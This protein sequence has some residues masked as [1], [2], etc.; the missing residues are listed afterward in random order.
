MSSDSFATLESLTAHTVRSAAEAVVNRPQTN[1]DRPVPLAYALGM[2]LAMRPDDPI[3]ALLAGN[4]LLIAELIKDCAKPRPSTT[5]RDARAMRAEVLA[6]TRALH[7]GIGKLERMRTHAAKEAA[8]AETEVPA[9]RPEPPVP[10]AE[11]H[12]APQPGPPA[13]YDPKRT[14]AEQCAGQPREAMEQR[15]TGWLQRRIEGGETA[16]RP[17]RGETV[18]SAQRS[19]A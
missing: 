5:E 19:P 1:L 11:P 6:L 14:L 2:I 8:H 18:A 3:Q 17:A 16:P 13:Q 12:L 4:I 7:T 15:V 9:V 10:P